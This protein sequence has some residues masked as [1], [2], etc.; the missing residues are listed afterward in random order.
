VR[1]E[2]DPAKSGRNAKL[3]GLPFERAHDFD[4]GGAVYDLDVRRDYPEPRF[5]AL[6]YLGDRLHSICFTPVEG[7][8][9]IISFRKASRREVR[10]HA[11]KT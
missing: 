7:G 9:R 10:Y 2:F 8:V 11:E 1:I 6:G 4:W 3:R 5:V